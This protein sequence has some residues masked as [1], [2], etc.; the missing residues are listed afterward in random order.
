MTESRSIYSPPS[1]QHT[2]FTLVELLVVVSIIALLISIV[3]PS[4]SQART[5]ARIVACMSN[6]R[7]IM[8]GLELYSRTSEGVWP[9]PINAAG[10][11]YWHLD[12]LY[13]FLYPRYTD[14]DP[15][16][17]EMVRE[18]IF[19]CPSWTQTTP[20]NDLQKSYGMNISLLTDG[21]DPTANIDR[22]LNPNAIRAPS[23]TAV[24]LDNQTPTVWYQ[25][26]DTLAWASTRHNG[27]TVVG[28]ADTHANRLQTER[29][30]FNDDPSLD[31]NDLNE[32]VFWF[33]K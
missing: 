28:F 4:L 16:P 14:A 22:F 26:G 32:S 8:V 27:V 15:T 17:T 3:T 33:G 29:L 23:N 21:T 7:Q 2:G 6:Q 31:Q 20:A 30:Y 18:T 12:Y 1:T 11:E 9:A 25:D 5:E 19:E 13:P 10:D 24:V